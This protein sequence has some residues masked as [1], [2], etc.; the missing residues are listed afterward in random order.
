VARITIPQTT[1]NKLKIVAT[2]DAVGNFSFVFS[3]IALILASKLKQNK[4]S[5][6]ITY[7]VVAI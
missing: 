6:T 7:N 4:I 5:V 3:A 2:K 1:K